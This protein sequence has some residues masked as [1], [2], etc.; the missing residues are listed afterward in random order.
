MHAQ[1]CPTVTLWTIAC[2][3]P[4]SMRFS[5]QEYWNGLPCPPPRERPDPGI[6]PT[7]PAAPSWQVVSFIEPLGKSLHPRDQSSEARFKPFGVKE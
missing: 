3:A 2:Q 6:K 7:S 5:R 4:L 1:S